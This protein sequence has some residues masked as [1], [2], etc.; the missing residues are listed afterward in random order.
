MCVPHKARRLVKWRLAAVAA[1]LRIG[2][3]CKEKRRAA[4]VAAVARQVQ[5]REAH[6]GGAGAS[7]QRQ[8][9]TT[10]YH[11]VTLRHNPDPK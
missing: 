4:E 5:S 9:N 2:P 11:K 6:L 7:T 10:I 8:K 1:A 3:A